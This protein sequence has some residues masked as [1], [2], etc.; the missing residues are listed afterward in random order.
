MASVARMQKVMV[1]TIKRCQNGELKLNSDISL[2]WDG[3]LV[4]ASE[5]GDIA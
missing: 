3:M 5:S 1:I 2:R 4:L